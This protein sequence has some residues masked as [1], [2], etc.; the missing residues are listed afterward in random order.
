[1]PGPARPPGGADNGACHLRK[2][3]SPENRRIELFAESDRQIRGLTLTALLRSPALPVGELVKAVGK[4]PQRTTSLIHTLTEEG[5]LEQEGNH[6]LIASGAGA[7][8]TD[9]GTP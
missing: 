9:S 7:P 8:G 3:A 4:D 1:M 2:P 5:F 6:L